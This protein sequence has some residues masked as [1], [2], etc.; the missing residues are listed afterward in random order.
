MISYSLNLIPPKGSGIKFVQDK[1]NY[2]ANKLAK[3]LPND[4]ISVQSKITKDSDNNIVNV[5]LNIIAERKPSKEKPKH[6]NTI[7]LDL[8]QPDTDI[9]EQITEII[10]SIKS[11]VQNQPEDEPVEF[12]L[13]IRPPKGASDKFVKDVTDKVKSDLEKELPS[14]DVKLEPK[15]VRDDSGN[16]IDIILLIG[17]KP[18][19]NPKVTTNQNGDLVLTLNL[20][21]PDSNV[22]TEIT[23]VV[24]YITENLKKEQE[25]KKPE[26]FILKIIPPKKADNEFVKT[27]MEKIR[28]NL[29]R[30]Y[31]DKK[32][33]IKGNVVKDDEGNVIDLEFDVTFEPTGKT[34]NETTDNPFIETVV[35]SETPTESQKPITVNLNKPGVNLVQEI[36][37]IIPTI[38]RN[39]D[40]KEITDE[41]Y[42]FDM[43][44]VPP[45]GAKE[46]FVKDTSNYIITALS[47]FF[48]KNKIGLKAKTVK[49]AQ[50]NIQDVNYVVSIEPKQSSKNINQ[51]T[52]TPSSHEVV[53]EITT[54]ESGSSI[55]VTEISTKRPK[56]ITVNFD[57]PGVDLTKEIENQLPTLKDDVK[58]GNTNGKPVTF[59]MN[60][61]PPKGARDKFVEDTSK[62]LITTL[63]HLFPNNKI[64]V[65]AKTTKDDEGNIIDISYVINILPS[66]SSISQTTTPSS[67]ELVEEI[68]P[69]T[70]ENDNLIVVTEVT[71]KKP[72]TI[73]VNF[74][75]PGVDLTKEI[76][77]QLPSLKDDV[78]E[79]NVNK[80]PVTFEMNIQPPEG[81][82]DDFVRDTSKTLITTLSHLFPNNKI[83]VK[84]KTTKD[85]E[86]N[87]IDIS[88]VINILPST[89]SVSQTTTPSSR[90]LVEEITP[91]TTENDNLIVVTEVT[92]KKPKTITVNF[93]KP[94]VDLTKEITKQLPS[95]KDDVEESNVNKKPVTFEMNIQPPEGAKDDFVRDTSK[96]LIT[97]LS[98]LFPNNKIGV[99]AKTTKDDEGNIIDISY[100]INILPSTSSV[101]QTTTP[102]S[103]EIVE[104]ITPE[105]TEND[106]LIVVTEVTTKKPK[107]ITVNFDKPGVD[108]TKEITKQLPSLKDDVE[109]SNVNKKPVT[110]EMNIQPPEGAKDDFVRDTSKTLI[111]TL[112]HLFP[113]NRIGVKAKTTKDDEGNIID[114]SYVINI[115]PSTSSVSQ[116]TTP[117]SQEVIEEIT[118]GTTENDN[119]IV[120]TEVTTKKPKTITVNFDKPGVDLTKEI[121]KQLPSL[122]DDVEESNV[123][124]KPVTFE[125][126]IQPPEGAKDDFVRDTSK[127]L[128]TTLS[129]LFPNNKIG[130]KAKTTKDNQGNIVDISYVINILPATLSKSTPYDLN[131]R[132]TTP[133][134]GDFIEENTSGKTE[135]ENLT[136]VT[137]ATTKPS[138]M[139]E[140]KIDIDLSKPGSSLTKHFEEILP[141]IIKPLKKDL[142]QG[143]PVTFNFDIEPP[144]GST[145][146]FIKTAPKSLLPILTKYFPNNKID[147]K[148]TGKK[149]SQGQLTDVVMTVNIEPNNDLSTTTPTGFIDLVITESTEQAVKST[150]PKSNENIEIIDTSEQTTKRLQETT[151]PLNVPQQQT[152][153]VDL[154][155]PGSNLPEEV[156]EVLPKIIKPLKKDL[157][158]GKPVTFNFDI[159]PAAKTTEDFL[160]TAPKSLLPV[161]T[162][163]FP[164][165]KINVK[166]TAKKDSQ[167]F[168]TDVVL[169]VTVEPISDQETTTNQEAEKSTTAKSQEDFGN[170]DIS[171]QTT[172]RQ[173]EVTTPVNEP[174]QQTVDVDLSNPG[175]NLPEVVEE[176]L[177][178]IIKPLK[179]DLK[180]GKPV[181]FNFDI[182]PPAK[183]TEDFLKTA[184]KSLLPVLTKYFP[185]DKIN[186]KT[187]AKKDSQGFLTDVVLSVTVEPISEQETTTNREAEK[188]T[189]PKSQEDFGNIDISALTTNRQQEVTTPVSEPQQQTVDVDLSNPGS[190]LPEEVE[191]VLP[192]IIKPLKKDLK[193]GKPV[194]FNFDIEPPAKTTEDFLKTA[195]KSLLPVLTKYFPY[196]KINVKT[197]AKKDSQGFLTDV[198]LSVTVEPISEQETTTNREAEKSTTPKSQE[199]FGN[200]DISEQTTNR[201]QEVTTP[202]NEPQQQTVDVDLSNPGSNLP[203]EV[204]EVLPKIIKPLKKDL[205][206]GKPVTFNFDIEPPAK[207]TED[208]LKTAPKSL[209]PVLTKYF[210]YDKI[211]VKTTAK[212]DSQGFLTDVVLSVTVEP[213]AEQETTTNREAE[214]STTPKSQE[215]FGN[216]DISEQTT[217]RQQEVTTTVNEPQQQTVDVDLSNPGSNLPEE[218]E[219]VLP[220]IIKPLKKDL[221]EGKPVTFNFDIEPPAKTTEDFLKTAP[222]SL[223][224]VLTKYFPYD[225]INVKTTAKKDSQGFL[226]DV[227]LSVTVEPIAEQ[228]TTTNREAEKSTTPKSQ[229]DFGNIDISEQTT[230]RQQ[231]VTTTVNEPQQQTVDVDLSNPGSNLPEEVEEVLPKIIK[232][233]KKDLKEG[234]PVTFNFDIEPPA[235]TTED[236][237]KTAPKSLLPVLTKYFP[238]DKINVKTTAKKNSQ[239]FLTDVVL[240]VTVEPISEQETTTNREAEKSTTPKSQEDFGNI[241]I[242]EQTTNRQQEVTTPVSEPQ[243]QTVDVDLSNPGS[244]LPEEVEEVLPKIIKP[245]KKDLKDGKPVTF[246]FDIEPP[247]KT[248]EDFLKTAPKS[249]LPVLTKY[250]PYDKINV[251][252]TAKKD[253]QGFL[254]DVVLSVTVEP[255]SEQETTTNREAEK[256]T[257]PKSQEDFGNIDIS[258]QT[259]NRQL[260]VTTPVNEPQ[261]QT[262]DVDLSNPGSNLPEVV[263]EVLPKIIKPLKKDLKEGKPVTFNFDIEPPAKTTEDF[264]KTAPKSL[265]PVLTKY[266]P[267]D[268]INVKTTAKKDSQGFLTDVVLSVTVEPVSEQETTTNREAEKSTTPKTQED[269]GNIDISEQ[270]TNRQQEVTTPVSE[271]Q[272]QTVDVD[273]SNPGSNLPEE[274]EEVLPKIIKPLKKDLKDGKPVTFNFDIEPPAK[275]TED[276][277][278]TAP[279]S[280]LPVLT[281][282]FPYDKINVKTTAKKDSQG[283]LTDVVLSVTV[284]PISEQETTTNREAEKST[285]PKSQE[286]FGNIDISEQ[287]TN[288]QQEV[289]TPVNE[290]QQQTVDV[291]LSNPGSNLPEEVEEVLPK[292]IEPLKKDL[293]EGKPVTFNFDIEPPAKTTEEFL[294]TAPK[295]LLPVLTKYFPFDKIN[296]KTT[297]KKDSQGFLTDVVLSVTVE[298]IA[299]QE[300]T[301]NREAEKSTTPKSQ[302]DFG[303]IDISEQTTNRQQE[304]T[305]TVS[306]PQQQTVDVDLSNPGSN[307][308]EEVEEVL[309][310][311]IKPLKKD[312]KEGKPVT[313]NFDIEP[314]AK[315]TE[316]FLKTAPQSLLPVLTKYFPYDKIN[317]KTTAKKDSQGFLTDVVLSVTVE[318]IS[319]QETT[320]YREAEKSTTPKSQEDFGNI[321]ISE[322]TTNPQQEVTTPESE[323]QQQTVDVDLSNPGSNLPEEVEEVLPKIIKPLK[324]DLKEGK[325]VTFNFD[326]EPPAKTT[327]DFLKTAPKS[328]LP[329][330]TK[331]FPYDKIN[332]K[333]TAKK[334]SQ[335]FITDVVLSVT[336]E[337]IAEQESTTNRE[338]EKSTTPKSEED[339]G[340]IDISEQTTNRQQEVTTPEN[341]PQQQTVDVDLSNP[342][343]NL[344]EEVEE[345]L[346][347][348]IKPL[349]KDLKEGKPVTFNFDIEP[350]AKTTEDFLK[351]APKSLLPVLTKYFPFD[352]INVKTTAKKDSQGFLTDVVLSVTVEP[353]SEQETTTNREAEKSTTPKS[354]ENFENI[355]IAELTTNRPQEVTTLVNEPQ[356]QTLDVDLSNPGSNLPEEV[357]KVL[358]KIIK[359][360]KKDLKDG[361][362]VTINF[363]IEPP[364][365]TTEDFL[366]TAPKSLLP[367]LTKYFPYDKINVKTTA[368][369]DSEGFLTDVVLIV[370]VEPISEQETTTNREAEKSTTPKSQE[371]FENIDISEQTTN[372]QQE[373]TTPANKPQEQTIDVDLSNPGSSLPEEVEEVLPKVIKPLKKD[374]KEGKPVILNFDIEPPPRSTDD[375]LKSTPQSLVPLLTK[376]FPNNKIS[377]RTKAKQD[378]QGFLTDVTLSVII[379]PNDEPESTTPSDIKK[380][381]IDIDL[382]QPDSSLPEQVEQILPKILK[383]VKNQLNEGSPVTLD[384]N[385][386][387]P[388]YSTENFLQTAPQ[389]LVPILSKYF[390]NNKISLKTNAKQNNQGFL[391]DVTLSVNIEPNNEPESTT[392]VENI[393]KNIDIDLSEPDSNL[394]EQ[395]EQILPKIIEPLKNDLNEGTPVSLDFNIEPPPYSTKDFLQTAPQ[396]LVP[397]LSKYF[398]NNKI[399][400]KTKAK[401]DNQ[402]FLTDVTLSV[403]I[404]PNNEPESTTPVETKKQNIDIDLSQPDS[405]LPQ[406]VEQILP[407][408]IKPVKD[409]LNE[410]TPVTLDFN[411]EPPP[412]STKDFL[413]TAPQ[414]LVPILSK[415]F[416]NNKISLKTNAKQNNQGFL[417]DVTLSVI[418]EPND[419]PEST[420]PVETKKQN[421]DIDLSQPDSSLP[422]QVEQILPKIIKPVKDELNEGTPVTLDFNIEPPPYSTKDFLQTAP[423]SL[424]PI[425]SKYFPNNKISLK[426]NAKQNNQGF[427]T[428]VTLSV[429]IEPN[430]EPETTT[431]T[432][433]K[434]RN[435]DID[436]SQPDSSLPQQV[437]QILPKIIKPVKNELNEGTPVTLDFNIEPPPYSTKDFLQTAP[438]S[439]VPILSKYFPNNK[440]SLKTKAEEDSNG[441]LTTV[442]L[443]VIIEPNEETPTPKPKERNVDIDLSQPGTTLPG[444]MKEIMLFI[445]KPVTEDLKKKIP[446]TLKFNIEPPPRSTANFLQTAPQSIV[447]ILTNYFPNNKMSLKT[448]AKKNFLGYLSDVVLSITIEPSEDDTTSED[449][450]PSE[451]IVTGENINIDLSKP[452][453]SITDTVNNELPYIVPKIRAGLNN[454]Q[455]M[456]VKF[457]IQP[458]K[459]ATQDVLQSYA[460]SLMPILSSYFPNN[461]ISVKAQAQKDAMGYLTFASLIVNIEPA[462]KPQEDSNGLRINLDLSNQYNSISDQVKQVIPSVI[463]YVQNQPQNGQPL[464]LYFDIKLPRW[465][466]REYIKTATNYMERI[467]SQSFPQNR[468]QVQIS[469]KEGYGGLESVIEMKVTLIPEYK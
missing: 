464:I 27:T 458:P 341:E 60:I 112:S 172:N 138:E 393:K 182:E 101:S 200:I 73:T 261:Q 468:L 190:N 234:K 339:F 153:D 385:I 28:N 304:V 209:L 340:N 144:A 59:E 420:T 173:Q 149:N 22:E 178:K 355:D 223:L 106:N 90:E 264:L 303:N 160:K 378:N 434:N 317:V 116:T 252:T 177:P 257:T 308:P 407:K 220:K 430:D 231:E 281:K 118:P 96:T 259:T 241:D 128:I 449:D 459:W 389:S 34:L 126:N 193:D 238:Y 24:P 236:F 194:T 295:S 334:D 133:I 326:I 15:V 320:T 195:P 290:P 367:V 400:L 402:G 11:I 184:P 69:G 186:V 64:G 451:D 258:E 158:E 213:I 48:P 9:E 39:V 145:D 351:T 301:T 129:H 31:P 32:V 36:M 242:S 332:V 203:E 395:V 410:G 465:A 40:E 142:N 146:D 187:T 38:R 111:T 396:S 97:T 323:P 313:F 156:E 243:Q 80:K 104:E 162:K 50:G 419:E 412:Y 174:Q 319:E 6:R 246:N 211:N 450:T 161:L 100:V 422:Q 452:R 300:T 432:D 63:S 56:T 354:Q 342:G 256:S 463:N 42:I 191:E 374:L 403:N 88:Y 291:D 371:D 296:V 130:V 462:P 196:D 299:E 21:E 143:N 368:K 58:E 84:A 390:P 346:P 98:H 294:K 176:V 250:F 23:N 226:T 372:R 289:T 164:Y 171:E 131:L 305:T 279:K 180:E 232:P 445:V 286:D 457:N 212:K 454:Q 77:K 113:N 270:T 109:E 282:Y 85:D 347:K 216:I 343:S 68:T 219:E 139:E 384:F 433:T 62:N 356:Q 269:F 166:T 45:K 35:T 369:K 350:P 92:T 327:E 7:N 437:E 277:L 365:K 41:P 443:S 466:S 19:K 105:T 392:P 381:N 198:V 169:S 424:V 163:Y 16:I 4:K 399:S 331:Y 141:N 307:L 99:K 267:Y 217:N 359:P 239:G 230:N 140:K 414:S 357:E 435:I 405:S 411:I 67:R 102:S 262:V 352:K 380:Q 66:T 125:M 202:V 273:L 79:S 208:F 255:I 201:Q 447:S 377:I 321:D 401:Q 237:L 94:G 135:P 5:N 302:E 275:T 245:L 1:M 240:S 408:I 348:I 189:T 260:E 154:S 225:K 221:K 426:T 263:E 455:P 335:G 298:P 314:P 93:D 349:K 353:I 382:S 214:K 345:V 310:K 207:T 309:P 46:N 428:D 312:L 152:V 440:I 107:T 363:D 388:P 89:S 57:K 175:S 398:P 274:V 441:F 165:D 421:I 336:V 417:T 137:E 254:T 121:T 397:I 306:E 375:F 168:L 446:V 110:F 362:P 150:T 20:E 51:Q 436:L 406:Q 185:Y 197:T 333:T 170:I 47:Q 37:E 244:N 49:D 280:L 2:I 86:G 65:K 297:A 26:K 235:K 287:T 76:T 415:Y 215:D 442:V 227:V 429:N 271:P 361:K 192:K 81:A 74:D 179:K 148:A 18:K 124:K 61:E 167:G 276:F 338:A 52:T 122:K 17:I 228:E 75:K 265:L 418:I 218:V 224:P 330:L 284:E 206:E 247:A 370:T 87:I 29:L 127:T 12:D 394:P 78:E 453:S 95:L 108:L 233:L 444:E 210:P 55:E 151:T 373:I 285:T 157:K 72:K 44:I 159:E 318:P 325:P 425:L 460:N 204:E 205:K 387:P 10:P 292:I 358:P 132:T 337:P 91:G 416:P 33:G 70:T 278:K 344:P 119:L 404:E 253:S 448:N 114:I 467:L 120:V 427:L 413:Q 438:Q 293:K 115:L 181:T 322:Q 43:N 383:P 315:A 103:Q 391:T 8:S 222:K 469:N 439:L 328:L 248:T 379:E 249:L 316:D 123:N 54:T 431:P 199:D 117:S 324:K 409:E 423:Q 360:L 82:K 272:Q 311:I 229:E 30:I 188:S 13:D 136:E 71:T 266:F 183:T 376:Y 3:Y 386:E 134:S 14:K 251:K 456:T 268:K 329:V 147:F 25:S 283:F 53:E 288:R 364:A 83:G 461:Q 155:K 366:K